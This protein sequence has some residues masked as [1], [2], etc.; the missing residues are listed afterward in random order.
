MKI[1]L[2]TFVSIIAIFQALIM[3]LFF[4][5]NKKGVRSSNRILGTMI[6][7]YGVYLVFILFLGWKAAQPFI[8]AH[9]AFWLL[10]EVNFCFGPLLYFYTKSI[11]DGQFNLR[12]KDF[13][14]FIPAIIVAIIVGSTLFGYFEIHW[15]GIFK[16]NL[17]IA[18]LSLYIC[19]ST[20][21]ARK[22]I[23][24]P[25]TPVDDIQLAWL[26]FMILAY[27]IVLGTKIFASLGN[28]WHWKA[29]F[30]FSHIVHNVFIFLII[31]IMA[32]TALLKPELFS[33]IARYQKSILKD[34]DKKMYK[35]KLLA[36]ME[37][38]KPY[39]DP[40]CT[41][42]ILAKRLS[43]PVPY[44][45]QIVNETFNL[46]F[47]DFINRYRIEASK[48]HLANL[49]NNKTTILEIAYSVGFYSK[50]TFNSAFRRHTGTSP[51]E[52]IK[53]QAA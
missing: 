25:F 37:K 49:S 36:A 2:Y 8:K 33:F 40:A 28:F 46:N 26:R 11:I 39:L 47:P 7:F 27:L 30:Y 9:P 3:S 42:P 52:Y 12:I 18:H 13:A 6:S 14:H 4:F 53:Q 38:E 1:N 50:S 29:L 20:F 31:N 24:S 19:I 32:L 45:S 34:A 43:I 15:I 21:T 51:K 35:Q 10:Y 22:I 23:K 16:E 44:L 5:L 17:L 41:L 48:Q